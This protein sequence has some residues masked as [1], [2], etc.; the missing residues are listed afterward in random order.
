MK[1]HHVVTSV[2]VVQDK[3]QVYYVLRSTTSQR[4]RA[5][6]TNHRSVTRSYLSQSLRLQGLVIPE[7]AVASGSWNR[8][9]RVALRIGLPV[10]VVDASCA[11]E[12]SKTP[13][14]GA[15]QTALA[16]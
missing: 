3:R 11:A 2:T 5:L 9:Q 10:L 6:T 15:L 14:F 1:L 13:L 12:R 8:P 4:D 16:D 7:A